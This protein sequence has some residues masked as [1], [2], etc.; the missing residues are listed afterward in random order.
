MAKDKTEK[1][2]EVLTP[3]RGLPVMFHGVTVVAASAAGKPAPK[4][5][6]VTTVSGGK[7]WPGVIDG[8]FADGVDVEVTKPSGAKFVQRLPLTPGTPSAK[9]YSWSHV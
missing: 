2:E 6:E 1:T 4:S 3:V 5:T 8:V 7:D 9:G